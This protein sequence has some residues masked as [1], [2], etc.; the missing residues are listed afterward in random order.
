MRQWL[1]YLIVIHLPS[2]SEKTDQMDE[3]TNV[4]VRGIWESSILRSF[5]V[6]GKR[7]TSYEKFFPSATH[8]YGWVIEATVKEMFD[9]LVDI[10]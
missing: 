8:V 7:F 4:W 1:V 6:V 2:F 3:L 5:E 9:V 10:F